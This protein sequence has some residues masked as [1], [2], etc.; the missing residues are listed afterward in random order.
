MCSLTSA[1]V[2]DKQDNGMK[3]LHRSVKVN[4][5]SLR[6]AGEDGVPRMLLRGAAPLSA[7]MI[8][9]T[10][11]RNLLRGISPLAAVP[12]VF[13]HTEQATRTSKDGCELKRGAREPY[14]SPCLMVEMKG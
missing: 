14:R 2:P 7:D 1:R 4:W 9:K 10:A 5:Q 3:R 12:A 8:D 11:I 6:G 13:V